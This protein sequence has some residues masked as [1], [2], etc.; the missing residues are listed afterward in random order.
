MF[1]LQF[2]LIGNIH[3]DYL[4]IVTLDHNC[5]CLRQAD[6]LSGVFS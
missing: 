4:F 6:T 5:N 2:E 3:M 1:D